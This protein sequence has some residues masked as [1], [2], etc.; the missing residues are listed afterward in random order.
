LIKLPELASLTRGG[1]RDY[2]LMKIFREILH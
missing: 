1:G 2:S